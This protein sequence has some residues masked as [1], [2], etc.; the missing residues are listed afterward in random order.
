MKFTIGFEKEDTKKLH[1][2]W[3]EIIKTHKWSEGKFTQMFEE[4]WNACNDADSVAFSSW[5]GAALA[6]L[7]FFNVKG[8]TVLCP[9]NTF[10]ATPLSI[11]KAG[12]KVQFVDC[13]KNDLCMSA[14]DLKEKINKYNPFAVFI[15]HIGGHI[16]FQIEEIAKLCK[17]KGIILIEDCAHSHGA[18]WRGRKAGTWGNAGIYSFYSTK[19]ISTGEGGMLVTRNKDLLNYAKK[20]RNYGKFEYEVEGLN[21]RMNEFTAAVGCVQV[22]RLDEIVDWK[23][24]YAR[25]Y[26]DPE[27]PN[28]VNFP[29]GMKSGYYKYIVFDEIEKSTGKVYDKPCHRIL[30]K[31]DSLPNTDWIAKNHWCVPIYYKGS[32][33]PK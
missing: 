13:N 29:E 17:E 4:R 30:K 31:S 24:A 32:S 22:N 1:K 12:G 26:L 8:K 9:A 19:T 15:V 21:Y 14:E 2:M 27:Y 10:M 25:K 18:S 5:G 23:N 16:A 33:T 28:R 3:D 20:Y 11:M 6:V 7:E